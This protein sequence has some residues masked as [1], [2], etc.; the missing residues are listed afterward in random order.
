MEDLDLKQHWGSFSLYQPSFFIGKIFQRTFE[1]NNLCYTKIQLDKNAL[2]VNSA[3]LEFSKYFTYVSCYT[4]VWNQHVGGK[5]MKKLM[6]AFS[7]I[8]SSIFAINL[9]E[10]SS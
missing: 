1:A 3:I 7:Q 5:S 8:L 2:F 6:I 10:A 4:D 9:Q